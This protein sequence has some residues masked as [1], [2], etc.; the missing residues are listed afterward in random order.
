MFSLA[1]SSQFR[2]EDDN[3]FISTLIEIKKGQ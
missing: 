1:Y 3:F 2:I